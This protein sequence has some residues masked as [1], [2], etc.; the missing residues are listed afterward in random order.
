MF[1]LYG[2]GLL[3]VMVEEGDYAL[4]RLK[5][6]VDRA[7][8]DISSGHDGA[9]KGSGEEDEYA[10]DMAHWHIYVDDEESRNTVGALALK[11]TY[12]DLTEKEK[13]SDDAHW[14]YTV[15]M[16]RAEPEGEDEPA[17]EVVLEWDDGSDESQVEGERY[18]GVW[19]I[20]NVQWADEADPALKYFGE[21]IPYEN[22]NPC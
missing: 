20:T 1:Y 11:K 12:D 10:L 14:W 18:H 4:I 16:Q 19:W 22:P 6:S 3:S 21:N 5:S 17:L 7:W 9:D 8:K 13:G 15:T 2:D